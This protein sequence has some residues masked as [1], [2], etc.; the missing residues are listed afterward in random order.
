[1]K[2]FIIVL[3]LSGTAFGQSQKFTSS[4]FSED[5]NFFW[6]SIDQE[7]CYFNKKQCDWTKV[8]EMYAPIVDTIKSRDQFVSIL[9]KAFYE[10][11]DHHASLNTNTDHSQ[12]LVPSSTDIWAEFGDKA[13]ITEVKKNSGAAAAG[14]TARMEVVAVNGIA[15]RDAIKP[16]LG[17]TLKLRDAEADSYALRLLL[18][19]NHTDARKLTLKINGKIQDYFP[20]KSGL[21]LNNIHYPSKL[22]YSIKDNI[23]YI[24]IN[25]CLYDNALIGEFDNA[26]AQMKGTKA[27]ILDL[28]ET[29][30][31]GNTN[32]ARAI[33]GWFTD[34]EK[35]YQKHE[36]YG[37]EK[38]TG[39]KRSW[40]EIVSPRT[41]KY[42][43]KPLA[44]LA[45]HWTGSISEGI[46]IG[47]DALKRP[48]TAI[49]GTTMARLMG[50]VYSYEMPNTKIRFSFPA[51]RLYHIDGKPREQYIPG[52]FVDL[53][54]EKP[55]NGDI[56]VTKAL[57]YFKTQ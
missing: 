9:E 26:M 27:L 13:I 19:G 43:D 14:I 22:D 38:E 28:R 53:Q 33:L 37:D 34:K 5:F 39:I 25:N 20:D 54:N 3:F 6:M 32:V 4:Q 12:R 47:F 23:G 49:V 42:Y 18:A 17:K 1:M 30:S 55:A 8:K 44:V 40:E 31:G 56:F 57:Q 41:G 50:A 35:F 45:D 7:Y 10:I 46:V 29:P 2:K 36:Y 16:F 24:K 21:L 48:H 52:I 15:V 51:E 11:Y